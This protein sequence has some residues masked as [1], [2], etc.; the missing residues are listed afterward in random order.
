MIFRILLLA[1]TI[2]GCATSKTHIRIEN[3]VTVRYCV[4]HDGCEK[5]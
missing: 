4:L 5:T 2:S 3:G 1:L